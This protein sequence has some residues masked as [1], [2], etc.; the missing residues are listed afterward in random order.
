MNEIY[1]K[2]HVGLR[3][4][5]FRNSLH[6]TQK[7]FAASL[8]CTYE[9]YKKIE[10]GKILITSERLQQLHE[11]YNIDVAYILT[12]IHTTSSEYDDDALLNI[13]LRVDNAQW[14]K[15]NIRLHQYYLELHNNKN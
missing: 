8:N 2:K 11:L 13:K 3:L 10:N 1:D 4:K 7:E 12:G 14:Q 6:I 5:E 9:T 15:M